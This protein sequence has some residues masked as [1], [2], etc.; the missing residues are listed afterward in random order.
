MLI[1]NWFRDSLLYQPPPL[2]HLTKQQPPGLRIL[3]NSEKPKVK[4]LGRSLEAPKPLRPSH[5]YELCSP[6]LEFITTPTQKHQLFPWLQIT[7]Q[8]TFFNTLFKTAYSIWW[9]LCHFYIVFISI[10]Y[11]YC[12]FF[13]VR[14]NVNLCYSVWCPWVPRK[15]SLN[16]MYYYYLVPLQPSRSMSSSGV[17]SIMACTSDFSR[18]SAPSST[19]SRKKGQVS[20]LTQQVVYIKVP[21]PAIKNRVIEL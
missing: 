7:T 11:F 6:S 20:P 1:I 10:F 8:N 21:S 19:T 17:D 4:F 18:V 13:L 5:Y 14:F 2:F 15:V 12:C 3:D 16:K 9:L